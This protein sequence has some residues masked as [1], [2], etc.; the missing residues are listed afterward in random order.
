MNDVTALRFSQITTAEYITPFPAQVV[1]TR[2]IPSDT[3]HLKGRR[4]F[5]KE[6]CP[7]DTALFARGRGKESTTIQY[8]RNGGLRDPV[9]QPIDYPCMFDRDDGRWTGQ[10]TFSEISKL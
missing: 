9:P 7:W 2:A 3:L 1:L 4:Y 5:K 6:G 10:E 8:L